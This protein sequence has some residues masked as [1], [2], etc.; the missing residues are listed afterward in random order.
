MNKY[1]IG[2]YFELELPQKT[3]HKLFKDTYSFQSARAAF[4]SLLLSGKP[5]KVWIPRYICDSMIKPLELAKINFDFYSIDESFSIIENIQ[6]LD[7]EWLLYVNYF[8]L[9][10][11][12][13]NE[14][15]KKYPSNQVICDH[16]Q[17]FFVEPL[18]NCLATI[19][20]LRKFFGVPDGGLMYTNQFVN[21][22]GL[23]ETSI[24]RTSHLLKRIALNPEKGYLDFIEAE[25]T[26]DNICTKKMST[27]TN[28]I[29]QSIDMN[30]VKQ[31]RNKNFLF[32]HKYLGTYNDIGLNFDKIKGP[33][34]YPFLTHEKGLRDCLIKEKIFVPK[35][36]PEIG[37]RFLEK[38]IEK[39][40]LTELLPIP[41]D[42]RYFESDMQR[43]IETIIRRLK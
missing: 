10:S 9:C 18:K 39:K 15:L 1:A 17:A 8:G 14:I 35:Y 29:L 41:C 28:R 43:I 32:L 37:N 24:N 36:W 5:A 20:S 19:Y 21:Q 33:L 6:L 13:E 22:K 26:L 42:Q 31:R 25:K 38:N 11:K 2:G 27:L 23:D 30:Y 12:Q 16:S 40:F 3:P 4:Y 7:N 34:C